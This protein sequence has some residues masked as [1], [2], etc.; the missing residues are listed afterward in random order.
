ML[1]GQPRLDQEPV[2]RGGP[3]GQVSAQQADPFGDAAQPAAVLG[4]RRDG[5][6]RAVITDLDVDRSVWYARDT[7]A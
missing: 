4:W 5:A 1:E 6:A 3:D 7:V 2:L